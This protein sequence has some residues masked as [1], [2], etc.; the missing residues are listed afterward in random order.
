[1]KR[2]TRPPREDAA[3]T[4]PRAGAAPPPQRRH[5]SHVARR[6]RQKATST[7]D[8]PEGNLPDGVPA[9][10]VGRADLFRPL[11]VQSSAAE[12]VGKA[13]ESRDR[14]DQGD[15][16]PRPTGRRND[17]PWDEHTATSPTLV[18]YPVRDADGAER[19]VG[20]ATV[21]PVDECSSTG[22]ARRAPRRSCGAARPRAQVVLAAGRCGE[23]PQLR[24]SRSRR[25]IRGP[26]CGPGGRAYGQRRLPFRVRV[27][28]E[29]VSSPSVKASTARRPFSPWI[30]SRASATAS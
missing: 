18:L 29:G 22:V 28:A 7:R 1:M 30:S 25:P 16:Q 17:H 8:D 6:V 14:D 13:C 4:R 11:S 3:A 5:T 20:Q 9:R 24:R 19:A 10:G 26:G 27:L 21:S 15:E 23:L 12:P 2:A